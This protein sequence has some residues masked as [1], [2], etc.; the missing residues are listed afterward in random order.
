M[1]GTDMTI[2]EL[3]V[4]RCIDPETMPLNLM[5][6]KPGISGLLLLSQET[7]ASQLFVLGP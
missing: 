2:S 1:N 6:L 5:L 7:L 3:T 4:D